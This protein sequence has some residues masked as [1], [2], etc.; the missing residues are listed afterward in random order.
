M[1]FWTGITK[2]SINGLL[3]KMEKKVKKK[4]P[5]TVIIRLGSG[6]GDLSAAFRFVALSRAMA[7]NYNFQ[8]ITSNESTCESA[9]TVM[10]LAGEQRLA[11]KHAKF[12]FHS[13]AIG[14]NEHVSSEK[15]RTLISQARERWLGAIAEVDPTLSAYLATG[16]IM[17]ESEM[18]YISSK[19]LKGGYITHR[20][21]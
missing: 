17:Y 16:R 4:N 12:G 19:D 3:A 14:E 2:S 9:C 7:H 8:L 6:G 20:K 13:P 5:K 21:E 18:T 10:Y 15:S 1:T 11:G